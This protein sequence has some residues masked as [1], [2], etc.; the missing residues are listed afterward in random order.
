MRIILLFQEL[1][2][3][4]Y[5]GREVRRLNS[6]EKARR[7][8]DVYF[9]HQI[10]GRRV[11][12]R[13]PSLKF[14]TVVNTKLRG[15]YSFG[16]PKVYSPQNDFFDVQRQDSF[17]VTYVICSTSKDGAEILDSCCFSTLII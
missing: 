11:L 16:H 15:M 12:V 4:E 1:C 14:T 10:D 2:L 6:N 17:H 8:D 3:C 13:L 9:L 7:H 5:V